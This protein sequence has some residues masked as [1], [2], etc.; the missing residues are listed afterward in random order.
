[1]LYIHT[2]A[3]ARKLPAHTCTHTHTTA[4]MNLRLD[5]LD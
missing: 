5:T 1:M 4:R 3:R 2:R